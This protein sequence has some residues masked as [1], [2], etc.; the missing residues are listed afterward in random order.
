MHGP[1]YDR[2]FTEDW[3][4]RN[5]RIEEVERREEHIRGDKGGTLVGDPKGKRIAV[6]ED[7]QGH[8]QLN[9][10]GLGGL[11]ADVDIKGGEPDVKVKYRIRF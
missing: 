10:G 7:K 2:A 5:E 4:N 1:Q 3:E 8:R 6:E 11:S 9:I